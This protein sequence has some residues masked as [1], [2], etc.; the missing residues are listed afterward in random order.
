MQFNSRNRLGNS[1]TSEVNLIANAYSFMSDIFSTSVV[2]ERLRAMYAEGENAF[3]SQYIVI[4]IDDLAIIS[5][6]DVDADDFDNDDV[7][8][9]DHVRST[10]LSESSSLGSLDSDSAPSESV[11]RGV[12]DLGM[13][14]LGMNASR[15][16]VNLIANAYSFMSDIFSTS[17]VQERLRAMYAEGENEFGG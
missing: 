3:G 7:D 8:D 16:E 1:S 14:H 10:V 12:I 15:S 4:C 13:N 17:V 11:S 5:R 2:Q 6:P 9:V